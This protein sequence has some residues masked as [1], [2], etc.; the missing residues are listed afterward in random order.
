MQFYSLQFVVFVAALM[1]LYYAVGRFAKRGQ[2]VVLLAGSLGFYLFAGWQ[3][4]F[5][6]VLT[7][8]ST[9]LV[10]LAF[11]RIDARCDKARAT[12]ADRAEKK[13]IKARFKHRKWLVLLAV[14]LVNF[15]VLGY[16]K[17]WNT[18]LAG[19]GADATFLA[20]HLLLPLG[21]SFYTFQSIGYT[22][23]LYNGKYAPER[24]YARYLLFVSWFPQ[25]IQGPINRFDDMAAQLYERHSFDMQETRRALLLILFGLLKKYVMADTLVSTI[26]VALDNMSVGTPGS[27][28]AFGILLYT[29]QQYGDF[30]GGIDIVRGVSELFGIRMAPNFNQPYFSV[31]LSDF[32]RRWHMSL[33]AWMRDYVFYPLAVRPS[34]LK[35]NKWGTAHLGKHVGRTLSACIG[36]VVVFLLVGLWHGAETHYVLWGLYNGVIIAAGDMMKPLFVALGNKLHINVEG[37]GYHLFAILR[38]FFLVNIGRYFD[39]LSDFGDCLQGFYNTIFNFN[40]ADFGTWFQTYSILHGWVLQTLAAI[41]GVIVFI[42]SIQRERGVDVRARVL[43]LP[44]VV[45]LLLYTFLGVLVIAGVVITK[46]SGVFLYANF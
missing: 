14:M 18:L 3:N 39:R 45:R 24:N 38:T 30:S 9:W 27:V 5:F 19:F 1:A 32:W 7:S 21:I 10:G 34:L 2:W 44:L 36:N 16:I 46:T 35:L 33:G 20:S 42:V 4:L 12:A 13:A 43:A 31:S 15:G 41:A 11:A 29:F 23:D 37:R 28:V 26:S 22:I 8:V 6:I 40:L 17:Y 25:L